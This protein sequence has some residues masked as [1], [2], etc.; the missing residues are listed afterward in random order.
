MATSTRSKTT[1]QTKITK[2]SKTSKNNAVLEETKK[3][4]KKDVKTFK[5]DEGILCKS[6]T[7]GELIYI[8]KKS[9]TKYIFSNYDDTCEIEVRD[10]NSLKSSK[11]AYL[12][13]PLFVI[14]DEEF[15][16][17]PKWKDIR[18][19]YDQAVANDINEIIDKPIGQFKQI[20]SQLNK[21]YKE[22]LAREVATR[23]HEDNFDSL[24][25]I[26]A[27]DEICG[28]DLYCLIS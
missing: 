20:I 10:L 17:Q 24:S 7:R 22:A 9:N 14:E 16:S 25:K 5:E 18:E 2:T 15:L 4:I 28:T 23:I 6:I 8:G 26:K 27:I 21:G 3:E 1:K 13:D 11:S 12:Y 19:M